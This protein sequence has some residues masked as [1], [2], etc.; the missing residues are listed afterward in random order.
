MSQRDVAYGLGTEA[1]I[2][3]V[4]MIL[5]ERINVR[6]MSQY[7]IV[8]CYRSRHDEAGSP[9]AVAMEASGRNQ[10]MNLGER[11]RGRRYRVICPG[12]GHY[13]ILA[14]CCARSH[15]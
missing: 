4:N 6:T 15:L 10:G 3:L 7:R 14:I 12:H 5:G 11:G 9:R 13:M 1:V 8:R 2:G